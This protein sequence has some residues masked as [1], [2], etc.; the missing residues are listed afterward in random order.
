[1]GIQKENQKRTFDRFYR[2]PHG[3]LHNVRGYGLGLFYVKTIVERHN[4]E[5]AVKSALHKGTEFMIKIPV[6]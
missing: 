4:W 2:V 5:I 6:R 3:N 1:M